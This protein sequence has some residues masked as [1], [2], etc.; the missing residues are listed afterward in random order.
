MKAVRNLHVPLPEPIYERLR[1]EATRTGRPATQLAREAIERWLAEARRKA[2][3]DAIATYA[4]AHAGTS[5]DLDPAL[6]AAAVEHLIG[7]RRGHR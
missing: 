2:T 3:H 1:G 5:E 6:E 4:A 7:K